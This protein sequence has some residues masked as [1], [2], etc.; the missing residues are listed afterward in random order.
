MSPPGYAALFFTVVLLVTTAYFLMGGLPLLI[1]QHDT[2][3]DQRFISRFFALYYK[4]LVISA[5]A[6]GLSYALWGRPAFAAGCLVMALLAVAL[7]RQVIPAM[8][9]LSAQI[10]QRDAKAVHTFRKVHGLALAMNL[11]QLVALVWGLTRLS[12]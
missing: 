1:L 7:R 10:Q 9:H 3:V 11:V 8:E 6:A 2:P 12:L 4:V 5:L